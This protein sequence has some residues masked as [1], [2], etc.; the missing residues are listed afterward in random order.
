MSPV[1]GFSCW[2]TGE[3][4][5]PGLHRA[6]SLALPKKEESRAPLPTCGTY[7]NPPPSSY[8]KLCAG[9]PESTTATPPIPGPVLGQRELVH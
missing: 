1:G 2:G 8:S 7:T 3:G 5:C 9:W 6:G 4:L